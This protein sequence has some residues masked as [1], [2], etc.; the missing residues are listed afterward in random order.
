MGNGRSSRGAPRDMDAVI[1]LIAAAIGLVVVVVTLG[2][3]KGPFV[4]SS[5]AASMPVAAFVGDSYT[6]GVGATDDRARWTT[7]LSGDAGWA[8]VNLGRGGTGYVTSS[9]QAG[10]GREYCPTYLEMLPEVVEADPDII[11]V[12]GGQNDFGAWAADAPAVTASIQGTYQAM[13]DAMPDARII[14][15]GPST[16]GAVSQ[17]VKDFDAAV[18]AAAVQV[19]ADYVGLIDPDAIDAAM[20]APDGGHVNDAGHAAIAARVLVGVR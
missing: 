16:T 10:C 13:R 3:W 18:Q 7:V 20:V 19:G 9:G 6:A 15:V 5:P 8:E 12:S 14:A 4:S 17:T 11:V 1:V 2:F